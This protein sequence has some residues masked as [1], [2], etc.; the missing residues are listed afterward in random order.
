MHLRKASYGRSWRIGRFPCRN[1]TSLLSVWLQPTDSSTFEFD[2]FGPRA[3]QT[4]INMR[5]IGS[6]RHTLTKTVHL[7]EQCPTTDFDC[8]MLV[9]I[10]R[11][12]RYRLAVTPS[13]LR[14]AHPAEE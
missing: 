10:H 8:A 1:G 3:P 13:L 4:S 5:F 6:G 9:W 11:R 2:E 12:R 14:G 7:V